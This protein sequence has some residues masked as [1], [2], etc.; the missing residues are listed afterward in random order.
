M[1]DDTVIRAALLGQLRAQYGGTPKTRIIE[2]FGIRHG[3]VRADVAV[4]NGFLQLFEIKS[5][6]DS[7]ARLPKQARLYSLVCDQAMLVIG[8]RHASRAME[9]VPDWWGVK[10]A[11]LAHDGHAELSETRCQN[12]NPSPD[13][14]SIAK[15]LWRGEALELLNE[16]G[17]AHGVRSKP[18]RFLYERLAERLDQSDL[19]SEVYSR[20]IQRK[21][22]RSDESRV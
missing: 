16:I 6:L 3:A 9:L 13:S 10:V 1:T 12:A 8:E 14:T 11:S 5:D 22:W 7:L 4:L 2:E 17:A 20:I 15:L 19:R 21:D 18:R